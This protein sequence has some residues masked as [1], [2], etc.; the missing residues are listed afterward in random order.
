M[1]DYTEDEKVS[2]AALADKQAGG[3]SGPRLQLIKCCRVSARAR[4]VLGPGRKPHFKCVQKRQRDAW[5]PARQKLWTTQELQDRVNSREWASVP[6]K[7]WDQFQTRLF[8]HQQNQTLSDISFTEY[9][10]F[11]SNRK[12]AYCTA[13]RRS[14]NSVVGKLHAP[15]EGLAL[16]SR[17]P[18]DLFV[19]QVPHEARLRPAFAS[20]IANVCGGHARRIDAFPHV[21]PP[22]SVL[23]CSV[24]YCSILPYRILF[25]ST[26]LYSTLWKS[27][28]QPGTPSQEVSGIV[29]A[30]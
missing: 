16:E 30:I 19:V 25:Y 21:A 24:L 1:K 23:R 3:R 22:C 11:R 20:P 6:W 17:G 26:L 10:L 2:G 5:T 8:R 18:Q 29:A 27:D 9:I 13:G 7:P 14:D 12:C 15:R 4:R 28:E